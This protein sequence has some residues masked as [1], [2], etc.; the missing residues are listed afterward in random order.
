VADSISGFAYYVFASRGETPT[1]GERTRGVYLRGSAAGRYLDRYFSEL[2]RTHS[3][4]ITM[5]GDACICGSLQLGA[6]R[7]AF[8]RAQREVSALPPTWPVVMGY[9]FAPGMEADGREVVQSVSRDELLTFLSLTLG[10]I[11]VA[12]QTGACVHVGGGE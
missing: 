8:E 1:E 12:E 10:V 2:H 3:V 9:E 4:A 5:S 11:A 6:L 7:S